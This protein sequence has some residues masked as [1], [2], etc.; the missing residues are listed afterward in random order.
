MSY[1]TSFELLI[2]F[3]YS[4]HIISENPFLIAKVILFAGI[5]LDEYGNIQRLRPDN[6][7]PIKGSRKT[8]NLYLYLFD[9]LTFDVR[10]DQYR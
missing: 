2:H 9:F 8:E 6:N 7:N 4:Q 10:L 1:Y 3:T 5:V